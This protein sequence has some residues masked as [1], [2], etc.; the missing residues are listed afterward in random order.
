MEV[1]ALEMKSLIKGL[2]TYIP[3]IYPIFRSR[4]TG[5]KDSDSGSYCYGVWLKHLTLLWENNVRSIPHTIAELGPEDSL[6]VGL[7]AILSGVSNYY[8]LDVIRHS[9]TAR[10]LRIFEE[11][12]DLFKA[13][14]AR[15]RRDGPIT[16]N[17]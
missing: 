11:L 12:A 14:A 17:T 16:M 6:G 7:A 2:L 15:R 10:N 8:G 3:G 1:R 13:R 9:A 4:G 5:T